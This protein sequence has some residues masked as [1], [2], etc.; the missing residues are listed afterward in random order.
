[1]PAPKA[2]AATLDPG[3]VSRGAVSGR[4]AAAPDLSYAE[5]PIE[6]GI[7]P[8]GSD[9]LGARRLIGYLLLTLLLVPVQ[10]M[11]VM[12][13]AHAAER[14]PVFYHRLCCRLMGIDIVT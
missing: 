2:D 9:T 3:A 8:F 6:S 11:L 4:R 14:F 12:L 7:A 5:D 13:G 1:M 10:A